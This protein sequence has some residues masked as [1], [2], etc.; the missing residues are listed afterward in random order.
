MTEMEMR[1]LLAKRI[2]VKL[3]HKHMKLIDLSEATGISQ[4]SLT[5]YMRCRRKPPYDVIIRIAQALGCDP[6]EL[7]NIDEILE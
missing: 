5:R 1:E 6:G 3:I 4:D 7:I 2:R